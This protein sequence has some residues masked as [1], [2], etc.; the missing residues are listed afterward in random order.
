MACLVLHILI[1]FPVSF[2]LIGI[3]VAMRLQHL[4]V[5]LRQLVSNQVKQQDLHVQ[6][7]IEKRDLL[8]PTLEFGVYQD[9][10]QCKQTFFKGKAR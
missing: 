4:R 1:N 3:D 2:L 10:Q 7:V 5:R 8:I 9:T 6:A